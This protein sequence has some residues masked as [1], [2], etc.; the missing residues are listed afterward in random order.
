MDGAILSLRLISDVC[1][2]YGKTTS[3]RSAAHV[4][5]RHW[6]CLCR[7]ITLLISKGFE[8][9]WPWAEILLGLIEM[10]R[11]L[12]IKI[13]KS[14]STANVTLVIWSSSNLHTYEGF[15][16]DNISTYLRRY[17]NT[18]RLCSLL[19]TTSAITAITTTFEQSDFSFVHRCLANA[20]HGFKTIQ[21]L[22]I[23][24]SLDSVQHM[25]R[26]HTLILIADVLLL[27]YRQTGPFYVNGCFSEAI[28]TVSQIRLSW[29]PLTAQSDICRFCCV[30]MTWILRPLEHRTPL[31]D[32]LAEYC[33]L[34]P[35]I[36]Q[37]I[38][39]L[40]R[41]DPPLYRS[42][43]A[44]IRY[45]SHA[46]VYTTVLNRFNHVLSTMD[47]DDVR[48]IEV[49]A[50]GRAIWSETRSRVAHYNMAKISSVPSDRIANGICDNIEVRTDKTSHTA[51]SFFNHIPL[52]RRLQI[53]FPSWDG[54]PALPPGILLLCS[55]PAGGLG[56]VPSI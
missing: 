21:K 33:S 15:Q 29:V 3:T 55:V 42:A 48:E 54:L 56:T 8:Q 18:L 12:G 19:T 35:L 10:D 26:V 46:S 17:S 11:A 44:I 24:S 14:S 31:V 13:T 25:K 36:F 27:S 32:I 51:A 7:W 28:Q 34:L 4:V 41:Q 53:G 23:R 9:P 20:C 1:L 37:S 6:N 52:A 50:E 40:V 43:V 16:T 5:W 22:W 30:I 47:Q 39:H 38:P 45:M 49:S 2:L